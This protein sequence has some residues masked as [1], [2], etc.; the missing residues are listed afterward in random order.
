[1]AVPFSRPAYPGSRRRAQQAHPRSQQPT[2]TSQQNQNNNRHPITRFLD[3]QGGIRLDNL[4]LTSR[5]AFYALY[6]AYRLL[7]DLTQSSQ[8]SIRV[9]ANHNNND[10]ASSNNSTTNHTVLHQQ[11][12]NNVQRNHQQ[13]QRVVLPDI[14]ESTQQHAAPAVVAEEDKCQSSSAPDLVQDITNNHHHNNNNDN[15]NDEPD[16]ARSSTSIIMPDFIPGNSQNESCATQQSDY[17]QH[18]HSYQ[19]RDFE[20]FKFSKSR[21]SISISSDYF[22]LDG[23]SQVDEEEDDQEND[24][25][26]SIK[27]QDHQIHDHHNDN[28]DHEL[29]KGGINWHNLGQQLTEIASAFEV[30]YAPVMNDQ[31]R[32]MY[33]VY[34]ELKLKTLAISRRDSSMIGLAKTICRQV[35]LSSIWILLKKI[36]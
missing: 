35:L 3:G 18:H 10:S 14:I 15:D 9:S 8:Q 5:I 20:K 17:H 12:E 26:L 23:L 31:Q 25:D 16:F 11:Q 21:R 13:Q 19:F 29:I 36:M 27:D 32:Q 34:R 28:F 2:T 22:S 4:S 30:T 24:L 6:E 7:T 1:M 33:Q